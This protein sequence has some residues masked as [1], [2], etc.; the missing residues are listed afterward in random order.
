VLLTA[1]TDFPTLTFISSEICSLHAGARSKFPALSFWFRIMLYH[2][3]YFSWILMF[4]IY[5]LYYFLLFDIS[6]FTTMTCISSQNA[7]SHNLFPILVL[8]KHNLLMAPLHIYI[9]V[10]EWFK[11]P[12]NIKYERGP[13]WV[14]PNR[15]KSWDKTLSFTLTHKDDGNLLLMKC[16]YLSTKWWNFWS[17]SA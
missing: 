8:N 6:S 13:S 3:H 2:N 16:F 11:E 10:W 15:S 1:R 4:P 5:V 9:L 14:R 17:R 7:L 12:S